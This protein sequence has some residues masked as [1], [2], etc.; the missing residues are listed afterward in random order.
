MDDGGVRGYY[1]GWRN[2][3][4]GNL[5]LPMPPLTGSPWAGMLKTAWHFLLLT[6]STAMLAFCQAPTLV[7]L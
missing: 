2:L 3:D 5:T 6:V 7:R 1:G 4:Y